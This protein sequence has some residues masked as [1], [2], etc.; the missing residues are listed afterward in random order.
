MNGHQPG[1]PKQGFLVTFRVVDCAQC[2]RYRYC[3]SYMR[4]KIN[5]NS[6]ESVG[7]GSIVRSRLRIP[8]R[9]PRLCVI[10]CVSGSLAPASRSW[11]PSSLQ[12]GQA[13]ST[14]H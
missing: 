13:V 5:A 8:S 4:Y 6:Q 10:I 1:L 7:R 2:Y 9:N 11:V 3:Y 14:F 12:K